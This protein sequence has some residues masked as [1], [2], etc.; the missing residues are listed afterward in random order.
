MGNEEKIAEER[1][2]L[3]AAYPLLNDLYGHFEI[4]PE[5]VDK[6][7]AAINVSAPTQ[8]IGI[9][10]TSV[11]DQGVKAYLNE[12]KHEMKIVRQ[13]VEAWQRD[14]SY[15]TA[16]RKKIEIVPHAKYI[17]KGAEKKRNHYEKYAGSGPYN[18]VILLCHS[19]YIDP[20][21]SDRLGIIEWTNFH[22]SV[23]GFP[24]NKV[25]FADVRTQKAVLVYERNKP[26]M[27]KPLRYVPPAVTTIIGGSFTPIHA[28]FNPAVTASQE[29]LIKPKQ[30]RKKKQKR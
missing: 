16:P 4:D 5:Q 26:L 11:D 17:L 3:E 27:K 21:L 19:D 30:G 28:P 10:I 18:E 14:G 12:V 7:D 24:Y 15:V 23:D 22:M 2:I 29:P 9:E 20:E 1:L 8:R 25:I 6:P 13:Q